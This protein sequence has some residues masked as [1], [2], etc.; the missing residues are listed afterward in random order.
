M[1]VYHN[2]THSSVSGHLSYFHV[3]D[4]VN[5]ASVNVGLYVSFSVMIFSGYMTRNGVLGSGEG[6]SN[7][8][9]QT[10]RNPLSYKLSL[11]RVEKPVGS[12]SREDMTNKMTRKTRPRG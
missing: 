10:N 1:S 3:L 4:I 2:F 5:I 8:K 9:S 6:D 12:L 11:C 7:E